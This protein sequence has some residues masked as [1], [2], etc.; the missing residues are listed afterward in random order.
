MNLEELA[1]RLMPLPKAAIIRG[2]VEAGPMVMDWSR[3]YRAALGAAR[4]AEIA[5]ARERNA[6]VTEYLE[7]WSSSKLD[8]DFEAYQAAHREYARHDRRALAYHE[9][10]IESYRL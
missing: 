10:L 9:K 4:D 2:F 3:V 7:A 1:K 5:M 8:D 6:Q